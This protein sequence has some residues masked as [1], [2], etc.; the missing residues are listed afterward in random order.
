MI[1]RD[2]ATTSVTRPELIIYLK[3]FLLRLNDEI[4]S[5]NET[6]ENEDE[7]EKR[8]HIQ[9]HK[10]KQTQIQTHTQVLFCIFIKRSL[11]PA[12]WNVASE[13]QKTA[14]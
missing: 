12:I 6:R 8:V 13:I 5:A 14:N 10:Q 9:I 11:H 1:Q 3:T 2:N 7:G 4:K